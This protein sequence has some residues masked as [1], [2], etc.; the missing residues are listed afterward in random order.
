MLCDFKPIHDH[1]IGDHMLNHVEN[2][3]SPK[4]T[5][6]QGKQEDE[7]K[8][9]LDTIEES[10]EYEDNAGNN[11]A[12]YN[13]EEQIRIDDEYISKCDQDGNDIG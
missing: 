7:M 1:E 13:M 2:A 6:M 3:L 8:K 5:Q 9:K 4:L 10:T 12:K 11:T